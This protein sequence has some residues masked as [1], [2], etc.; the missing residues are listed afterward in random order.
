[1]EKNYEVVIK[2]VVIELYTVEAES[3]AE[4]EKLVLLGEGEFEHDIETLEF[5][6]VTV[7]EAEY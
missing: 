5:E 3:E 7:E 6:V 4:A 2:R 1:M